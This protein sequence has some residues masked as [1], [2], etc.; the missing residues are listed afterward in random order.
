MSQR[1]GLAVKV[2][3]RP[4]RVDLTECDSDSRSAVFRAEPFE[5]FDTRMSDDG[6][7]GW[8]S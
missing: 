3:G 4:V 5:G 6:F 8:Q 2:W 1:R 7:A